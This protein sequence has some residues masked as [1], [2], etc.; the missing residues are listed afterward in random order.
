MPQGEVSETQGIVLEI[1]RILEIQDGTM[2]LLVSDDKG[3]MEKMS[4]GISTT[5]VAP[6]G[7]FLRNNPD[8]QSTQIISDMMSLAKPRH[9]DNQEAV[10]HS[11][12]PQ[13]LK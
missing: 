2:A 11:S 10:R 13:E 5:L 6:I 7:R 12:M 8:K 9:Y 4:I 1:L 3:D